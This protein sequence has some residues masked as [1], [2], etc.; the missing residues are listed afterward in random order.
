MDDP[1]D[2]YIDLEEYEEYGAVYIIQTEDGEVF[3][4]TEEQ[5]DLFIELDALI[6]SLDMYKSHLEEAKT[7]EERQILE[8]LIEEVEKELEDLKRRL[9]SAGVKYIPPRRE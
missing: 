5:D 2:F 3:V 1:I 4:F 9:K 8:E 6:S 7:N